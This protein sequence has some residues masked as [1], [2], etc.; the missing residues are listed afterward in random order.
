MMPQQKI[1]TLRGIF[2]EVLA[3]LAF[4]FSDEAQAEPGPGAVWL[5][6]TISYCG[7]LGGTLRLWC[8]R[9]FSS[10]LAANLLGIDPEE[11]D[12]QADAE[13]AVKEFMNIVCGQLVTAVHG[14]EEVFHLT[15]PQIRELPGCPDLSGDDRAE[16]STLV[17]EGHPVQLAYIPRDNS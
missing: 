12:A 15:I 13:D 11:Q 9:D 4:M 17:V 16:A 7:R 5:E 10:L 8:T 14:S 2:S 6:T 3:D 1:A